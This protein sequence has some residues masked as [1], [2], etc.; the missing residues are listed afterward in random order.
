MQQSNLTEYKICYNLYI[1]FS[2]LFLNIF[3]VTI[4]FCSCFSLFRL[5]SS[6]CTFSCLQNLPSVTTTQK[7]DHHHQW[8]YL[9]LQPKT[10]GFPSTH[11]M[12]APS[13]IALPMKYRNHLGRVPL[14]VTRK[15]S[16]AYV[17]ITT[18]RLVHSRRSQYGAVLFIMGHRKIGA[19]ILPSILS[20]MKSMIQ[21]PALK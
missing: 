1:V 3:L 13:T 19:L 7:S 18:V 6:F 2:I 16:S 17:E 12:V 11:S 15:P 5:I 21:Q 20:V 4:C 10:T 14:F 9:A 8:T